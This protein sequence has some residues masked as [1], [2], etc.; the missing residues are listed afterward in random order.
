MHFSLASSDLISHRMIVETGCS[1]K[2]TINILATNLASKAIELQKKTTNPDNL[3]HVDLF[4]IYMQIESE[5][6][7]S[8][9]ESG[10]V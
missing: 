1:I 2:I 9:V 6:R 5:P 3:S 7:S 4:S 10:P 8:V